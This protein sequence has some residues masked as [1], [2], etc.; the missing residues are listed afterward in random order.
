[1]PMTRS[2]SIALTTNIIFLFLIT[3]FIG[4]NPTKSVQ[5]VIYE[6]RFLF[7]VG[8]VIFSLVFNMWR[9]GKNFSLIEYLLFRVKNFKFTTITAFIAMA[10][11]S[12]FLSPLPIIAWMGHDSAQFGTLAFF[13]S[14]GVAFFFAKSEIDSKYYIIPLSCCVLTMTALAVLESI[15][16]R[17]LEQW[18]TSPRMIYPA[19]TIGLRQHLGGWFAI[20]TLQPIFFYRRLGKDVWFYIWIISGFLGA[21]LC[22]TSAATI[23]ILI[24]LIFWIFAEHR[25]SRRVPFIAFCFFIICC[26]CAPILTNYISSRINNPDNTYKSY[27]STTTLKTRLILWKA[28]AEGTYRKPI[29]GWGSQTFP[30]FLPEILPERDLFN[31]YRLE[32]GLPSNAPIRRHMMGYEYKN[33]GK[34]VYFN[35]Q[36]I[37]PHN[38]FLSELYS[39]GI[40]ATLLFIASLI[41]ILRRYNKRHLTRY[42]AAF[43]P[44][45]FYLTFW[46]YLIPVTPMYFALLGIAHKEMMKDAEVEN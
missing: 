30:I 7:I 15:G 35:I 14:M 2:K 5:S 16:F 29:L 44:Y 18:V 21:A 36:Y 34:W 17:P 43:I 31:L 45:L 20:M 23:G 11:L 39:R 1:M 24:G 32:L 40:P 10:S 6:P 8:F 28:A 46:F 41:N 37:E 25:N 26:L 22:T 33:E 38:I 9:Q 4:R 13:L 3:F 19:A 12:A 27:T 42:T